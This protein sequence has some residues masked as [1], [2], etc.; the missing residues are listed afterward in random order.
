MLPN[1]IIIGGMKCGTTSLHYYLNQHPEI[2]MS[3]SKELNFF[4]DD[5]RFNWNKGLDWY[6]SHFTGDAKIHGEASPNYT[7][8]PRLTGIPARMHE[9]VPHAKL[10]YLVRDPI[11][12]MVSQYI[13][14]Y[15]DD[16]EDRPFE[17]ALSD[18]ESGYLSRSMYYMQLEQY[19]AY[20]PPSQILV[21][22]T[23]DLRDRRRQTLRCI[24]EFLEVDVD[25]YSRHYK[26]QLNIS[27]PRRRKTA[28]GQWLAKTLP[29]WLFEQLH[30]GIR[31]HVESILYR[32]FSRKID[33]PLLSEKLRKKLVEKLAED[34]KQL[35]AFTG[36][37]FKD[38]QV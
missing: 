4:I 5:P 8:Y 31:W 19:L 30:S 11:A 32:P 38:W 23:E 34:I 28:T 7:S 24:F 13:H 10:I 12:R 17:E 6:Q 14:A 20:Y 1:L 26:H 36:N 16:W 25:F 22:L 18:F 27:Q 3:G 21:I 29:S 2:R 9:I 33:R 15:S 35:R 37:D